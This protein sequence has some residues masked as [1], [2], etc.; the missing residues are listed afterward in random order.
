MKIDV[1]LFLIQDENYQILF[2]YRIKEFYKKF[3]L[4]ELF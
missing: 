2:K 1:R 4:F 3:K